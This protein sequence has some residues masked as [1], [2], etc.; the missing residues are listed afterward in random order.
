MVVMTAATSVEAAGPDSAS[1]A[2]RA[3]VHPVPARRTWPNA[4]PK[5]TRAAWPSTPAATAS[6]AGSARAG[7][8]PA[9]VTAAPTT[10]LT[11]MAASHSAARRLATELSKVPAARHGRRGG[12]EPDGDTGPLSCGPGVRKHVDAGYDQ[13][14]PGRGA[15]IELT[16]GIA[17]AA[18]PGACQCSEPDDQAAGHNEH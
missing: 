17:P 9:A 15:K 4:A 14:R 18:Q 7:N 13:Q 10:G 12:N 11:H 16:A 2:S 8:T 5:L 6:S 3:C 1:R